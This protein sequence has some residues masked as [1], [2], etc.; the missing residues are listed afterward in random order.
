MVLL[1]CF[2]MESILRFFRRIRFFYKQSS[3]FLDWK[4]YLL[5]DVISPILRT[6]C[7]SLVGYYA[8]GSDNIF[9]WVIG[10]TLLISSFGAI[11]RI[12]LQTRNE[13]INGT[14]PLLISTKTRLS[15]IFFSSAFST[16]VNIFFSI[17]VGVTLMSIIFNIL[18]T[19]EKIYNFS[20][21]LIVAIFSSMCFGFLFSCFILLSTEVHFITNTIERILLIFTGANFP[22]EKLP[23]ILQK[24]SFLFPLTHS[25]KA[26]QNLIYENYIISNL[27]LLNK[28]CFLGVIYLIIG[29]VVLNYAEK[30][31]IKKG[32]LDII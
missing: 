13:K 14:L 18:W 19:M 16:L 22:I 4:S 11:Y 30:I 28:E 29:V 24:F 3:I 23:L 15:E 25:I 1:S 17:I 20:L 31:A 5:L 12:G 32:T 7:F 2:K 26:A 21:I 27:E 8:Y 9:K 10:N 6:I